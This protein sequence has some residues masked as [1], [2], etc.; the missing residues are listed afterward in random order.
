[1]SSVRAV[2]ETTDMHGEDLS[3]DDAWHTTRRVGLGTLL[4]T[5]FLRFRYGDGF[6]HARAFALQLALA[7]VPL[8]IAG[9]G[10]ATAIGAESVA[11]VVARTVVAVSPGTGDQLL[12]DV[13]ARGAEGPAVGNDD[14]EDGPGED[15]GEL[16]VAFGLVTAFVAMTSAFAQ[17]ERG[18]NRVYGVERDRPA[19]RKY[20]RAAL[21]TATA[22]TALGV[23]LVLIVAGGPAGEA[24]EEVYH[25]GDTAE[26]VWDV[27]RWPVGLAALVLAVT[28]LFRFAPRRHQPG[29]SW[30][31]LG[32]G[33]TVAAWLVA[34]GAI[35][36]YVS[37]SG[38]FS[39]TYGPLAGIMVLLLWAF[40]T[41][42]ALLAGI[43]VSAQL[44]AVRAGVTDPLLLD[45]DDDGVPDER[46]VT[47][48]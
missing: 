12:A 20:S 7:T 11:Q 23:G 45:A 31:A 22:G 6:S 8:I 34:S 35:A 21:L 17:L 5:S 33:S 30:L 1:M 15:L 29:L 19:L 38:E 39:A 44:E 26:T 16:A 27:V 13:V 36:L 18:A 4:R 41:G 24:I 46:A 32:A 25:W 10:L 28:T 47:G 9:S 37:V 14:E 48:S 40:V 42:V 43:A 2:P 3:A